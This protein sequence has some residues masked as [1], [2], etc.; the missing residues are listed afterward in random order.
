M[1]DIA[2]KSVEQCQERYK[3]LKKT[4]EERRYRDPIFETD[5]I[6]ADCS[7][8]SKSKSEYFF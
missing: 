1:L 7:R 8:V 3:E 4:H 6:V 2:E 5:F